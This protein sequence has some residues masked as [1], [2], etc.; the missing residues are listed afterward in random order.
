MSKNLP[1]TAV[2]ISE[3]EKLR[4]RRN[5]T[6]TQRFDLFMKMMRIGRMLQGA[7]IVKP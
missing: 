6:H 1:H 7:R 5:L 4:L 2:F 3:D